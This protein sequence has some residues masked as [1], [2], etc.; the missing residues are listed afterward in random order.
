MTIAALIRFGRFSRFRRFRRVDVWLRD[1]A[2]RRRFGLGL[3]RFTLA[4]MLVATLYPFH[5]DLETASLARIDW[6]LYYPGHNDRDLVLNLLML[7]PLGT[8]FMLVRFGRARLSRILLQAGAL[9]FGL[10]LIVE[11]LQ[12]FEP[13]RYPQAADVWRNGVGCLTGAIVTALVLKL[14]KA[15]GPSAAGPRG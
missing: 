15:P 1:P 8:G 2:V 14:I 4:A 3:A 12:I 10:A 5:F 9:G 13:T 11:T 6:R 7:A